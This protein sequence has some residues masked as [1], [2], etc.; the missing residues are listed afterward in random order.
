MLANN[1]RAILRRLARNELRREWKRT[2][3]LF[4]A[5][6]VATVL[7]FGVLTTGV[8]YLSLARLQDTRLYGGEDDISVANGFTDEQYQ[9]LVT[10]AR[11]ESVGQQAYAVSFRAPRL[12][13]R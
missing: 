6:V 3:V 5:I 4:M 7:L 1:N 2:A 12:T 8:S 9:Q 11:V 10:D 13:I